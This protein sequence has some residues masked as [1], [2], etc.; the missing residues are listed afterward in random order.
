MKYSSLILVFVPKLFGETNAEVCLPKCQPYVSTTRSFNK[1]TFT[2]EVDLHAGELGYYK[3]KECPDMGTNP[4]LGIQKGVSYIFDQADI[5][6]YMHPL[7]LAYY[8]D[9]AH[10]EVDELEPG[11]S[12]PD[13]RSDCASSNSC[14]APMYIR[15]GIYLGKY[16]NDESV[17]EITGDE[18]FGLDVYEPEFFYP[19]TDWAGAGKY[20]ISLKFDVDDFDDDI[21]YF[22]HIHSGMN[23]RIKFID[24][25]NNVLKSEDY[26]DQPY[27]YDVISSFDEECG[28][29]NL[30]PF[31]LP[32]EQCP[33]AFVCD[34][35]EGSLGSYSKCFDAMNCAMMQGMTTNVDDEISLFM[36]QMIPHHQNAV[37]MA[38]ALLKT[39]KLKCDD[40]TEETDDCALE[41]ILREIIN[42]QNHQIQTMQAILE[43]GD[44]KS[45]NDCVVEMTSTTIK[46]TSGAKR[47]TFMSAIL[48][49]VLGF[50]PL[51]M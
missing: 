41:V 33:S 5:S 34:A 35:P 27:T 9:G 28:T 20:S 32:N 21:F 30:S 13:S 10:R 18:D 47:T 48:T 51:L 42:G 24:E 31:Q 44:Y 23:G 43:A 6:N 36:H 49:F 7:G 46:M 8:P 4:T 45:E 15:D 19:I 39:G 14:P 26:P 12:P 1:C 2:F 17:T 22:C 16:S 40:V 38:K 29:Y 37:N 25:N 3:V 11:I 50:M